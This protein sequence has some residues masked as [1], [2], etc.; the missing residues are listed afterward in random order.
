[1]WN[2]T[3]LSQPLLE[4]IAAFIGKIDITDVL[5]AEGHQESVWRRTVLSQHLKICTREGV[6]NSIF[7]PFPSSTICERAVCNHRGHWWCTW[8]CHLKWPSF[9]LV[10]P[11]PGLPSYLS[12]FTL[13]Y[14]LLLPPGSSE[15]EESFVS[16]CPLSKSQC[17]LRTL[18]SLSPSTWPGDAGKEHTWQ[19]K[20]KS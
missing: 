6:T 7:Q 1:M 18:I 9:L 13:I 5:G 11:T 15:G 17:E 20:N 12:S 3:Q 14:C 4:W 8:S 10:C 19:T 2:F 16:P